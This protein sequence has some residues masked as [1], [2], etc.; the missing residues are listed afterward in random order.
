[1]QL[2]QRSRKLP[3]IYAAFYYLQVIVHYLIHDR[4]LTADLPDDQLNQ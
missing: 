2:R 4:L 3:F 1:M